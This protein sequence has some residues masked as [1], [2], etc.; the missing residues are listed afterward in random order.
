VE[1]ALPDTAH[2]RIRITQDGL[3]HF[4]GAMTLPDTKVMR[5][6][7][8]SPCLVQNSASKIIMPGINA[9]VAGGLPT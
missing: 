8:T 2:A 3:N 5:E 9:L 4:A 7:P 1:P 6:K